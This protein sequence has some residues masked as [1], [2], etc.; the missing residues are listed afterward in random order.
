MTI[1]LPEILRD[2]EIKR[3]ALLPDD[4]KPRFDG[5]AAVSDLDASGLDV[6]IVSKDAEQPFRPAIAARIVGN[7]LVTFQFARGS[8]DVDT[9]E[10]RHFVRDTTERVV[11]R[12]ARL[13]DAGRVAKLTD[14]DLSVLVEAAL[15]EKG[16]FEVA[17]ALVMQRT[18]F[19]QPT[20]AFA[21]GELKLIRRNGQVVPWSTD[22]I[23]VAVRKAFLSM[24]MDSDPAMTIANRVYD[25]A[26]AMGLSYVS[27]ETVQDLVQEELVLA[28]HM[29]VA[30]DYILYRAKRAMLR[31]Q[32]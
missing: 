11:S 24:K 6:R 26:R 5:E 21:G 9:D 14:Y 1:N 7:A 32:E 8:A 16:A 4:Q 18:S 28:G 19:P 31:A 22:K 2:L 27:I 15:I 30:E 20:G 17:K 29:K 25:R 23:E 13:G 3:A 10:N 12:L